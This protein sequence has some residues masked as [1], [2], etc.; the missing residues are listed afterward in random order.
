MLAAGE[1]FE[2]HSG[3]F[4][5]ELISSERVDIR[6]SGMT[7]LRVPGE[8]GPVDV[9]GPWRVTMR[10]DEKHTPR[11]VLATW[12]MHWVRASPPVV[13]RWITAFERRRVGV[14]GRQVWFQG[15]SERTML[16]EF[17]ASELW[18]LGASERIRMGASAWMQLG[19]SEILGW[20]ASQLAWAGASAL[21]QRGAS[22][23]AFGGASEW[24]ARGASEWYAL[25]SSSV[26]SAFFFGGSEHVAASIGKAD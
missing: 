4:P 10:G 21:V 17:G 5:V 6:F 8:W 15:A 3:P 12:T 25:G 14:F 26:S 11:R 19:A 23:G 22:F 16:W 13:E 20:G 7:P 9:Y 1:V 18:R 2:W 24:Y